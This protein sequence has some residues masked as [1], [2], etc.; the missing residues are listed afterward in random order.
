MFIDAIFCSL[1]FLAIIKGYTKGL[2]LA[3]FSFAAIILGLLLALKLSTTVS[4][5][6]Q[7][8]TNI[9]N[10]WLPFISFALIML[11]VVLLAKIGAKIIEKSLQ[12][13][14]LGWLN[15]LAGIFL[16]ASLYIIILSIVLFY[17]DRLGF[18]K[19]ETFA[20]SKSYFLI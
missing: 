9:S 14:M 4:L 3:V 19:P 20:T 6:L 13:V 2:V 7:K 5:W 17:F 15:K 16:F 8:S 10:Y 18:I 12:L 11:G 1:I